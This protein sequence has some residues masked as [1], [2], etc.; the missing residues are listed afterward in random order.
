VEWFS[1]VGRDGVARCPD[2]IRVVDRSATYCT[3]CLSG[4]PAGASRGDALQ[5]QLRREEALAWAEAKRDAARH[6]DGR[7]AWP[8]S[9]HERS[10]MR[11]VCRAKI[12]PDG[13]TFSCHMCGNAVTKADI[14]SGYCPRAGC[15]APLKE[16]WPADEMDM[17][18]ED[19][20]TR[21]HP[22]YDDDDLDYP[23]F[24]AEDDFRRCQV[25]EAVCGQY[26]SYCPHC[27]SK[28][29]PYSFDDGNETHLS[30]ADKTVHPAGHKAG[31]RART[32]MDTSP[33]GRSRF[34]AQYA[35]SGFSRSTG[36]DAISRL[37]ADEELLEQTEADFARAEWQLE[38]YVGYVE[39]ANFSE[40][41][42]T[43]DSR[44][45]FAELSR[46][47]AEVARTRLARNRAASRRDRDL[48]QLA[49]LDKPV[50]PIPEGK[51]GEMSIGEYARH[52][53]REQ[54][55]ET[56]LGPVR[57]FGMEG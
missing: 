31:G 46:R 14:R 29:E 40:R 23:V 30:K 9:V 37:T 35:S 5:W 26:F 17:D 51:D 22:G 55:R 50:T 49:A 10:K 21:D 13:T 2:C 24:R 34:L 6:A 54:D 43:P 12:G 25:C 33:A 32:M 16:G 45:A 38:E 15:A 52:I 1:L 11:W 48:S 36:G 8:S 57:G 39:R 56:G 18:R 3:H 47:R 7:A 28:L 20:G 19:K 4:Q 27:G 41:A 42:P 53:E 44:E